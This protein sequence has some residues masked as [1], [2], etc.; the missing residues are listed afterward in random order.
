M[1]L[2]DSVSD[3][4]IKTMSESW[5]RMVVIKIICVWTGLQFPLLLQKRRRLQSFS[6]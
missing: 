2:F 4:E 6:S 3:E 5:L 1:S